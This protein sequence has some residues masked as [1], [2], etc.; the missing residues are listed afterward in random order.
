M[1]RWLYLLLIGCSSISLN[2]QTWVSQIRYLGQDHYLRLSCANGTCEVLLPE[3]AGTEKLTVKGNPNS[4]GQWSFLRDFETWQFET[5]TIPQAN[6]TWQ[7]EML[8][9][10]RQEVHFFQQGTPID[11]QQLYRYSGTFGNSQGELIITY[12]HRGFLR[13]E[14]SLSG[15]NHSLKPLQAEQTFWAASGERLRFGEMVQGVYQQLEILNNNGTVRSTL[16]RQ[17]EV[18]RIDVS[19]PTATDTL[20]GKLF[21]PDVPIQQRLPACLLLPAA[22]GQVS[23]E[24]NV[25]EAQW[26]AA[27]GMICLIFDRPGMGLSTAHMNFETATFEEKAKLFHQVVEYLM[28]HEQVDMEKLGV[29]G[30]SQS[31]RLA[32]MMAMD[33]PARI[34][35]ANAVSAPLMDQMEQQLYA[36]NH[37]HRQRHVNERTNVRT[38]SVWQR[39]LQGIVD[40][41]IPPDLPS[42]IATLQQLDSSLFLPP[43]TAELPGS[44]NAEDLQNDRILREIKKLRRPVF[45]QYGELDERVDAQNS[46]YQ[47]EQQAYIKRMVHVR[48]Y[49]RANHSLMTPEGA[50][51]PAY[52]VDKVNW[53]R[54]IGI[55]P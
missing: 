4:P 45:L 50:I 21:L 51:A 33:R 11:R 25:Y 35:F 14:S 18:R 16:Q 29:H 47:L 41:A 30:G 36:V 46:V 54:S 7:V 15:Q 44:P 34:A 28:M 37:F 19:I 13:M 1:S 49:H 6:E 26:L 10:F 3:L 27:H 5:S 31:G 42:E 12:P 52:L 32:I 23:M 22:A 24:N 40:G 8:H 39:Y 2:A 55:L 43:P 17:V 38:L 53:L 9:P 48:F 20:V